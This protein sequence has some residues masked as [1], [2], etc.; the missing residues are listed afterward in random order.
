M[1][2][3][4]V[5]VT[6]GGRGI[7]RAICRRFAEDGALVITAARTIAELDATRASIEEKGGRCHT[8]QVDVCQPDEV[9]ALIEGAAHRHGRVDV[10]VNNAGLAPLCGIEELD[11]SLFETLQAV[12]VDAVYHGCRAVWPVMV[13]QGGGVIVSISSV[14]SVDPFPGLAAYG[15]A[16]AWVN[17]WTR[18]LADEGRKV[19][20]RVFA[21]A[22]GA[23]K[24]R[25]LQDAFPDFPPDQALDPSDVADVVHSLSQPAC[26]YASGQ[27][28]FLK[29]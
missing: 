15:A 20:I 16:K 25:M 4:V 7:G 11:P 18:G 28:V 26:R 29:R 8:E 27:T 9:E 1:S 3:F 17:A 5:V 6:G 2:E 14:A 12:N 21:V 13:E 10:L 22:P 19:G 24:T 23:V